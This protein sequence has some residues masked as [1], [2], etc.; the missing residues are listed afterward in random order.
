MWNNSD[1]AVHQVE[2]TTRTK[3]FTH[4]SPSSGTNNSDDAVPHVKQFR[5]RSPTSETK[6]LGQNSSH[7][8][9]HQVKQN[10]SNDA[11]PHVKQFRHRSP[12]SETK[13]FRHRNQ[14]KQNSDIT[15]HQVKQSNV[16]I[17][18]KWNKIQ[19][20]QRIKWNKTM[21]TSQSIKGNKTIRMVRSINRNKQFLQDAPF[22]VSFLTTDDRIKGAPT[23]LPSSSSIHGHGRLRPSFIY[24][25]LMLLPF[26]LPFSLYLI[27]KCNK[28]G[29]F[30]DKMLSDTINLQATIS[31][32]PWHISLQSPRHVCDSSSWQWLRCNKTGRLSEHTLCV[33][34]ST[35]HTD[36]LLCLLCKAK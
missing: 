31:N 28:Y 17:P 20:S 11:V 25:I 36:W 22:V 21:Q 27:L 3:Q 4:R 15:V 5:H 34:S 29:Q 1:I 14:V 9:V 30:D 26:T 6:Q 32:K 18:I 8:A 16:D 24:I 10:N 33:W 2:Q 35:W 7:I 19:T 13:Q 23:F 12:S